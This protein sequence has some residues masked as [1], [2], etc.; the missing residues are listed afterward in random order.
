MPLPCGEVESGVAA[1]VPAV[2]AS[3]RVWI[4]TVIEKLRNN[5]RLPSFCGVVKRR[6]LCI[7]MGVHIDPTL[8]ECLN[9][10]QASTLRHFPDVSNTLHLLAY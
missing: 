2:G 4:S 1:A 8:H 7:A 9:I 3:S 5:L 10:L 6:Y